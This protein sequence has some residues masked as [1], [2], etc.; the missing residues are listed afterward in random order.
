MERVAFLIEDTNA[1][2]GCLLNP[3]S[4][5]IRR[6]AGVRPRRSGGGLV[7]GADLAD[8]QLLYSG[9]GSTEL[10]MNLLFDVSLAGSSIAADD[11]RDLTGPFWRLAESSQAGGGYGNPPMLSLI[12]I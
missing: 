2:I 11:V 6:Q 5:V 1:R 7:T 8:D 9:G 12:H 3:E 10:T 4:L